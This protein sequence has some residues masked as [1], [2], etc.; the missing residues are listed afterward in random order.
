[1]IKDITKIIGGFII[2]ALTAKLAKLILSFSIG[3][4]LKTI[5]LMLPIIVVIILIAKIVEFIHTL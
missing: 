3:I 4:G 5:T 2:L 1:M